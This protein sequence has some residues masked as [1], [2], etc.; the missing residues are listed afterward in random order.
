MLCVYMYL[1]E[2]GSTGFNITAS[3]CERSM[4]A[5]RAPSRSP[6]LHLPLVLGVWRGARDHGEP[7]R[8]TMQSGAG[9]PQWRLADR[10]GA[11]HALERCVDIYRHPGGRQR[12][13]AA[14]SGPHMLPARQGGSRSDRRLASKQLNC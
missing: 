10:L 3:C 9:G 7:R 2:A 1:L 13:L 14:A 4:P 8:S 5:R 11:Q 6:H 12:P